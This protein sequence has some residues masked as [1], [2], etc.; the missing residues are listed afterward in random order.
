MS[1]P[2]EAAWRMHRQEL[3]SPDIDPAVLQVA[4]RSY[5][6]GLHTML[7]MLE[8]IAELPEQERTAALSIVR[9]ELATFVATVGTSLEGMV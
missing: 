9:T 8:G 5:F 6:G 1:R 4:R 2:L 7:H 3:L